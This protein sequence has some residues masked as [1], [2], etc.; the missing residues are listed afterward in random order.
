[1][2]IKINLKSN[3]SNG[4]ELPINNQHIVNSFIHECLGKDNDYHNTKSD[5]CIS[6]LRGGKFVKG[7]K[8]INFKDGYILVTSKDE[9]LL[10]KIVLGT[11]SIKFGYNIEI[12]GFDYIEEEFYNGWNYF[13]VLSPFIMKHYYTDKDGKDRTHFITLKDD[14]FEEVVKSK[15]INKLNAINPNLDLSDFE[16]KIQNRKHNKVKLIDVNGKNNFANICNINIHTNKKVAELLY[17]IGIGS[18]TGSGFG[19]I[20]KNENYKLYH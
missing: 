6:N 16:L 1:M 7:T 9:Q 20:Y 18:S 14:D 19:T 13:Q 15:I 8:L 12:N 2:R 10:N 4:V 5:Y 17:H 11:L 3:D